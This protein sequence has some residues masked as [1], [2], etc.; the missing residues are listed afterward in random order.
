MTASKSRPIAALLIALV[1]ILAAVGPASAM[2][3]K[4][5]AASKPAGPAAVASGS[6]GA[7]AGN[8]EIPEGMTAEEALRFVA[9]LPDADARVLLLREIEAR[10]AAAA[11]GAGGPTGLAVVLVKFRMWLDN[12]TQLLAARSGLVAQGFADA[13]AAIA[14]V[15]RGLS[16]EHTWGGVLAGGSVGRTVCRLGNRRTSSDPSRDCG[17]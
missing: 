11:G 3:P 5:A 12:Q 6:G 16:P 17:I 14:K 4:G 9:Q 1:F 15:L 8:L 7:A 2:S 10:R 13:P